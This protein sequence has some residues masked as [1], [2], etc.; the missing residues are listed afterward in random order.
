MS[1]SPQAA[2]QLDGVL[3]VDK[4][5]GPTSHDVV[6]AVRRTLGLPRI[7]HAGTLDPMATGVLPL[8]VGR[9][10]RLAQFL[11]AARK[12]Y[13]AAVRFGWSTDTC[14]ALGTPVSGQAAGM[15]PDPD[16]VREVLERFRGDLLQR[17]PAFSAKKVRGR[18]SYELAR[19]DQAVELPP[20]AVTVHALTLEGLTDDT[21]T[22][23]MTVSA[24]FYVRALARD[25]GDALGTGAHLTALCRTASG[26]FTLDTA[27]RLEEV[28]AGRAA[29]GRAIR[30]MQD[31]L[32]DCPAVRLTR[33][34][35]ESV[36]H[37][38]DVAPSGPEAG[39]QATGPVRLIGPDGTL[40]AI[41]RTQSPG[42]LHPAVVLM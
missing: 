25:L 38:R 21:A 5:E 39:L 22:L 29:G 13:V 2:V 35:V 41:G 27:V 19:R 15:A 16:R 14:D 20:V 26:E 12:T 42:V 3:V 18:R 4:P 9:A 24:G 11:S 10:T 32:T 36:R 40:V 33:A 31:L 6:A 8:L 7:G 30:P 34:E 37:G 1:A 17:P 23:L 28:L